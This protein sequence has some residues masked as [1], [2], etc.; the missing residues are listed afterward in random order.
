MDNLIFIVGGDHRN[1]SNVVSRLLTSN[2]KIHF[3]TDY[4]SLHIN[5]MHKNVEVFEVNS[6][7]NIT[8]NYMYVAGIFMDRIPN[9]L[10]CSQFIE[11]RS[12]TLVNTVSENVF[13]H[14]GFMKSI[15]KQKKTLNL[16]SIVFLKWDNKKSDFNKILKSM[17]D[18]LVPFAQLEFSQLGVSIKQFSL[19]SDASELPYEMKGF[20]FS[21]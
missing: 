21:E 15:L 7:E 1:V 12:E 2:V 20:L 4:N 3:Y 16:Q 5:E 10:D 13:F 14:L 18:V 11:M 19:D 6:Y 17:Y 8:I 9:N